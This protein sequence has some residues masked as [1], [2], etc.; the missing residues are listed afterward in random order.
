M[1]AVQKK[2]ANLGLKDTRSIINAARKGVK[3]T[4]FYSFASV[5][6]MPEKNLAAILHLH[7]RTV[8]NYKGTNKLF[9]PVESEHL[10]K[11]IYLYSRGEQL[12]GNIDQ[13]NNWLEQP[14]LNN[15]ETAF[16]WL[17]TPGGVDLVAEELD[18]LAHGY[19]V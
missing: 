6:N 4:I 7:P 14:Y 16:E 11:L 13:F 2:F 5:V 15:K 1:D 8:S 9:S 18:R 17:N 19:V 3:A 12:F 10:L